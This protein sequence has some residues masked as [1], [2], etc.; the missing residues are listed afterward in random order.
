MTKMLEAL[1][2]HLTDPQWEVEETSAVSFSAGYQ[3]AIADVK[4][5]GVQTCINKGNGMTIPLYKL[6]EET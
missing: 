4:A 1:E 6:P 3:S 2:K 5:G